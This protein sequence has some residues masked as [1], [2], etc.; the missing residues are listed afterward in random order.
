MKKQRI[1]IF[2]II[3]MLIG[4]AIFNKKSENN[5]FIEKGITY[6]LVVDGEKQNSFPTK[7]LY[8]VDANCENATGKWDY[9]R[10]KLYIEEISGN[11]SCDISFTTISKINFNDYL[12]NLSIN[13]AKQGTGILEHETFTNSSGTVIDT[14]YRY[15]GQDPNNYVLF[16]NEL[17]RIVGVMNE[18]SHG[19]SD[20]LSTITKENLLI[21]ITKKDSIGYLAW[22]ASQQNDWSAADLKY[23]L[24]DDYLN[25]KDAIYLNHCYG[26]YA[27]VP[28]CDYRETGIKELY[29]KMIKEV[30]WYL[31]GY[32]STDITAKEMYEYEREATSKYSSN[33]SDINAKLG[34]IYA[35]DYGYAVSSSDCARST[36]MSAYNNENCTLNNWLYRSGEEW[37]ITPN[38]S[39]SEN[40]FIINGNGALVSTISYVGIAINPTLYLNENVY[41]LDGDGSML[42]PYIIAMDEE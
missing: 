24:N 28:S 38:S 34:L 4:F 18:N 26:G 39:N 9:E 29:K 12:I 11:V 33:Q 19:Q 17:W 16:N 6:A 32:S 10:W 2:S 7:G 14:G 22:D 15:E 13:S 8:R 37:T 25:S 31:G 5:I 20:D 27:Q 40:I 3:L 41:V 23:L 1:F 35:S 21:K 36:L 42:D 30:T